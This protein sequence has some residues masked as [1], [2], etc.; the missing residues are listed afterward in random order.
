MIWLLIAVPL[1]LLAIPFVLALYEDVVLRRDEEAFRRR[2]L[3]SN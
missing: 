1:A 2:L 3:S